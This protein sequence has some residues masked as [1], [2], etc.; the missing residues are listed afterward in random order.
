MKRKNFS[1]LTFKEIVDSILKESVEDIDGL[2]YEGEET[3]VED[4]DDEFDVSEFEAEDEDLE[5]EGEG[6]VSVTLTLDEI[7][8]LRSIMAK[9]D[10]VSTE[11]ENVEEDVEDEDIEDEDVEISEEDDEM[12]DEEADIPVPS[13]EEETVI[14]DGKG[15][16]VITIANKGVSRKKGTPAVDRSGARKDGLMGTPRAA[17]NADTVELSNVGV[18]RKKGTP[19]VSRQGKHTGTRIAPGKAVIE[20]GK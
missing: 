7:S 12:E 20:I 14:G 19:A 16:S 18:S 8:V 11:E 9:I 17:G 3:E 10:A 1:E 15:D 13:E 4:T 2:A 6:D 5:T